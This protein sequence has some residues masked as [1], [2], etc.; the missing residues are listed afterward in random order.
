[1]FFVISQS[2]SLWGNANNREVTW[3]LSELR[4]FNYLFLGIKSVQAPTRL[5]SFFILL[6]L[7]SFFTSQF[8][9]PSL[10]A[11]FCFFLCS[12]YI[13]SVVFV[14]LFYS[15]VPFV[16]FLFPLSL[17]FSIPVFHRV[18]VSQFV[19]N[20]LH[21]LRTQKKR[22]IKVISIIHFL[23]NQGPVM[24]RYKPIHTS[25]TNVFVGLPVNVIIIIS[26]LAHRSTA[27]SNTIAPF[28]AI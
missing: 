4:L 1:M 3:I 25:S 2:C 17:F 15:F 26:N 27:S 21:D 16:P 8:S 28:N 14:C 19:I 20:S 7:F 6:Y 12:F 10:F 11:S 23:S 18:S 5:F 24:L 13:F 9:Y 22:N